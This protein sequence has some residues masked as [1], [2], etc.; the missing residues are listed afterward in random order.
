MDV[1]VTATRDGCTKAQ[2]IRIA[3]LFTKVTTDRRGLWL[4]HGD[5]I[6]GDD[7]LATMAYMMG[8]EN[9]GHPPINGKKRAFNSYTFKWRAPKDYFPRNFDIVDESA[10]LFAAPKAFEPEARS[11]TWGTIKYA[12]G[13]KM[14]YVVY[15]DGSVQMD[16]GNGKLV[17]E[18]GYV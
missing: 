12:S 16:Y 10:V 8:Y 11:G 5:C 9:V 1:G 4:H 7:E 15:P 13:K 14:I 6:G 18:G 2:L 3:G 17:W